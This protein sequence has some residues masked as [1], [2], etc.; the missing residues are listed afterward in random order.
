MLTDH[1]TLNFNNNMSAATVLLDTETAFDTT[2][3]TGL[4]YK[5]SELQFSMSLI[6]LIRY[7][8]S[9]RK[10]RISIEGEM[11]TPKDIQT[12]V[13]QDSVLSPTLYSLYKWHAP[14][15]SCLSRFLCWR[16][17]YICDRPQRGLY[18][19]TPAARCQCYWD[20]VWALEP[21]TQSR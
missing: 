3:H 11:S 19:Q 14:N 17:H 5:L 7:F 2:W 12:G 13:P 16:H 4:L 10:S 1:V 21:K 6:K 8:H 18:Y 9:Q 20:V 15:T